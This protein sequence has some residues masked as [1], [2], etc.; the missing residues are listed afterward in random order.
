MSVGGRNGFSGRCEHPEVVEVISTGEN[1][2]VTKPAELEDVRDR[3]SLV[4]QRML[5][6]QL[7]PAGAVDVLARM[8]D[9]VSGEIR[10]Q[11]PDHLLGRLVGHEACDQDDLLLSSD[12]LEV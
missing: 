7:G 8:D 4:G 1:G 10:L 11:L 6:L 5:D 9:R 12:D 3:V 2:R